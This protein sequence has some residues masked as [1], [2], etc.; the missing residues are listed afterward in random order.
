MDPANL[1]VVGRQY[2]RLS[3]HNRGRRVVVTKLTQRRYDGDWY[4]HFQWTDSGKQEWHWWRYFVRAFRL[5]PP[6]CREVL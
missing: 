2:V 6:E 3:H 5:V 4:V 1:P